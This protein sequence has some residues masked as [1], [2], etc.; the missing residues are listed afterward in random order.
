MVRYHQGYGV[1]EIAVQENQNDISE[2]MKV[3]GHL[4]C[5]FMNFYFIRCW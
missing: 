1:V 2:N 5:R 3:D 4:V